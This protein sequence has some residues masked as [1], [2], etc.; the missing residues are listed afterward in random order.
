MIIEVMTMY[1]LYSSRNKSLKHQKMIFRKHEK[2]IIFELKGEKFQTLKSN[3]N[4]WPET[5]L[6]RLIQGYSKF[7]ARILCDDFVLNADGIE[8]FIFHRNP[9]H[10]N[11]ILDLYR[12]GEVHH[13][14]HVCCM[15]TKEDLMFWGVDELIMELCCNSKY[16][17]EKKPHEKIIKNT[18]QWKKKQCAIRFSEENYGPSI[19]DQIRKRIWYLLEYSSSSSAAKVK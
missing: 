1:D 2:P 11:T 3:F 17:E 9:D 15:T 19:R 12:T 18:Q 10:F 4:K 8:T 6:S 5:R 13:L 7:E 16:H 14:K